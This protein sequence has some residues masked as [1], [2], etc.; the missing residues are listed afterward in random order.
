MKIF[1]SLF[2]LLLVGASLAVGPVCQASHP[3]DE[4]GVDTAS[5]SRFSPDA[6]LLLLET[7]TPEA[8]GRLA[9]VC[10]RWYQA[11]HK[12]LM[13]P[14]LFERDHILE[15]IPTRFR[16]WSPAAKQKSMY[17]TFERDGFAFMPLGYNPYGHNPF[18][19]IFHRVHNEYVKDLLPKLYKNAFGEEKQTFSVQD[20]LCLE[21][22]MPWSRMAYSPIKH[23]AKTKALDCLLNLKANKS[24][25]RFSQGLSLEKLK[26]KP[27]ILTLTDVELAEHQESLKDLF[28]AHPDQRVHLVVGSRESTFNLPAA[29]LPK[30]RHLTL[31]DPNRDVTDLSPNFLADAV[32]LLS[33]DVKY[34]HFAS[35]IGEGFLANYPSLVSFDP[36]GFKYAE[37]LGSRFLENTNALDEPSKRKLEIFYKRVGNQ[38]VKTLIAEETLPHGFSVD[39]YLA[40][41]PDIKEYLEITPGLGRYMAADHYVLL[42]KREGRRYN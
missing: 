26:Q 6:Q 17:L 23:D 1:R 8:Q 7:L 35:D 31:S 10:K 24:P 37:K 21:A 28:S 15:D 14:L 22:V 25:V 18:P 16:N 4:N 40:L 33:L 2:N 32:D 3:T 13:A 34:L 38:R 11:F 36:S 9:T 27:H 20:V 29:S 12:N 19:Q 30:V 41:N 5:L 39:G 42:G